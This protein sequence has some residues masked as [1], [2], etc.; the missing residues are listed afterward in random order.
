MYN[1]PTQAARV[2][3]LQGEELPVGDTTNIQRLRGCTNHY[4]VACG[5]TPPAHSG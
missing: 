1:R 2:L 3:P 5:A 4:V